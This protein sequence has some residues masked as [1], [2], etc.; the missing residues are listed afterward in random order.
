MKEWTRSLSGVGKYADFAEGSAT[1]QATLIRRALGEG[2]LPR[3][4]TLRIKPLRIVASREEEEVVVTWAPANG[5]K[6]LA[7]AAL[8]AGATGDARTWVL[9]VVGTFTK[10]TPANEK[11]A[12]QRLAQRCQLRLVHIDL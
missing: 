12:Q 9:C 11:Q 4:D 7:W 3:P 2:W 6:H 10:P 8:N 5:L 1:T